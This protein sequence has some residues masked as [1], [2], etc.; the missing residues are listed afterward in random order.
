MSRGAQ[1]QRV[2]RHV[3]G[4]LLC[5]GR[6]T[7]TGVLAASGRL[8]GDW[9]ADYRMYSRPRIDARQLFGPVRRTLGARLQPHA[10][11]VVA[12][13]DTRLPKRGRKIHGTGY[14]RDPMGPPFHLNLIRAQ[15]F[16]QLSMASSSSA[17]A[18]RMVPIDFVHA[19]PAPRCAPGAPPDELARGREQ[20]RQMALPQV[21]AARL[22]HL[23][24]LMDQEGQ[25]GR[26]LWVAVD[27]GYTNR[28]FFKGLPERTVVTGRIRADAKLYALPEPGG[29]AT[30]RRPVYGRRLPTPEELRRDS[31][32][33]WL[34]VRAF[35]AGRI[36]RFKI[37]T[38]APVR[39]RP[40]A[41]GQDLRLVV[42]APLGYRLSARSRMLYRKPAHL[43]CTAPNASLQ[44]ILQRYLWR[45]D[46]ELNLRDEKTLLGVGQAQIRDPRA[47]EQVPALA[48]ASYAMLLTSSLLH[49]GPK[50]MPHCLPPPKWRA[51]A[52]PRRATTQSLLNHLRHEVWAEAIRFCSFVP[53]S[54]PDTKPHQP[55]ASLQSALFYVTN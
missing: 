50:G 33:P 6:H 52:P 47:V 26:T 17:T 31:S 4:Q 48:V 12:L 8:F 13:D 32:I 43:I 36:H 45:W 35:A 55:D 9:S 41:R 28:A 25:S 53:H 51:N 37:K 34:E 38:L 27:G 20:R 3:L 44:E 11:L 30:G 22:R 40:C 2:T 16:V 54:P 23:R 14:T 7:L 24:Q 19:P 1:G 49:Y 21:G 39:W 29:R 5:L 18:A 42:I 46:I 15:R 10:P